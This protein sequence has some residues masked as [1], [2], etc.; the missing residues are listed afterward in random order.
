MR[1]ELTNSDLDHYFEYSS[2][3]IEVLQDGLQ[4]MNFGE[5]LVSKAA[6]T[7]QDLLAALQL[8]DQEPEAK[9]G[10]CLAKLGA[11]G[12]ITIK[13]HLGSWNSVKVVEVEEEP[14]LLELKQSD[15]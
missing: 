4:S 7:R 1:P 10:E 15:A 3:G 2:V 11:M 14:I 9:I 8:Q 13:E 6:I 12:Y 5:Y